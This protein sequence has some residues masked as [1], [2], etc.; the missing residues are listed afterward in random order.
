MEEILAS[1][2][3]IIS[4]DSTEQQPVAEA[5]PEPPAPP[6]PPAP[7]ADILE[8]TQEVAEAPA[9]IAPPEQDVVFEPIEEAAPEPVPAPSYSND[10]I[11]SDKTRKSIDDAFAAIDQDEEEPEAPA[12]AAYQS[13]AVGG[14]VEAV[15]ERAVRTSF[16]PVTK[17]WLGANADELVEKMKPLI[18]E[19][20]DE[21]F[22][23]LL[24]MA[25]RDEVARVAKA[26]GSKR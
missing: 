25:V 23:A 17:E 11:F 7:D 24:E 12:P 3:K 5:K 18:R 6:P 19:W 15:F 26:R 22:P 1:I 14:T 4:E 8:L 21:H 16:V 20:M 10:G 2:R 13:S 9:P